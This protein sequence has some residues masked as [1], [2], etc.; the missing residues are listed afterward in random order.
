MSALLVA[1]ALSQKA[2]VNFRHVRLSVHLSVYTTA[3]TTGRIYMKFDSG[4]IYENLPR[5]FKF[6]SNRTKISGTLKEELLTFSFVAN[7]M[8]AFSLSIQ[9]FYIFDSDMYLKSTNRT[10]CCASVANAQQF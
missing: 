10:H 5:N 2:P 3:A 9:Y 7:D 1:F 4:D 8:E 6:I